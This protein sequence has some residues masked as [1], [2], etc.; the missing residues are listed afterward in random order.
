[1]KIAVPMKIAPKI[2]PAQEIHGVR[3]IHGCRQPGLVG[4]CGNG[5]HE[6]RAD[7]I[8]DEARPPWRAQFHSQISIENLLECDAD[9]CAHDQ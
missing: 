3:A 2:P 6:Y 8:A 7:E 1:M 4:H 9:S 5:Q